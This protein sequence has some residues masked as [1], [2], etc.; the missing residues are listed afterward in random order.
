[1]TSQSSMLTIMPEGF[2][3]NS[4]INKILF[5]AFRKKWTSC[6]KAGILHAENILL[7]KEIYYQQ[8]HLKCIRIIVEILTTATAAPDLISVGLTVEK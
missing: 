7:N 8:Q 2:L 1:M 6:E 4:T 5:I 3:W